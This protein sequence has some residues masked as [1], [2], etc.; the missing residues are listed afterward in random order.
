MQPPLPD[1]DALLAQFNKLIHE[2]LRG[3]I[4]RNTFRPWEI[5]VLLD[6][7]SCSLR[8]SNR[9]ETLRRY[10]KAVQRELDKGSGT[11][12]KLSEYLDRTRARRAKGDASPTVQV[13]GSAPVSQ[14]VERP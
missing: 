13:N 7:D 10:Q 12:L 9:R 1:T 11:L 3:T 5:D 8:D 6:I 14:P 2:L 4:N